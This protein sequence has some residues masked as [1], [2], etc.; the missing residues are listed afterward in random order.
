MSWARVSAKVHKWLALLMAIQILF[1]FVSGLFFAIAPIETVRS[2]HRIAE[3]PIQPV[4]LSTA[5]IGLQRIAGSQAAAADKI[6]LRSLLDK[7]VALVSNGEA[8]PRLYNLSTGP[9][10]S[11]IPASMAVAIAERDHDGDERAARVSQVTENTTEYRGPPPAW[12]IHFEDGANR[13]PY[14]AADTGPVQARR[15]TC[16]HTYPLPLSLTIN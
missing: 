10:I 11:T 4:S 2:E 16:G 8:R 12:R 13:A 15:P 7:P 14:V 9:Q 5:A 1:W 6:E 3:L